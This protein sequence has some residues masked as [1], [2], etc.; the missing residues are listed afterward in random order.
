MPGERT[1]ERTSHFTSENRFPGQTHQTAAGRSL[2]ANFRW[3]GSAS[4]LSAATPQS[5]TDVYRLVRGPQ[6]ASSW[7]TATAATNQ[8]RP[9]DRDVSGL[10]SQPAAQGS[11]A[12]RDSRLLRVLLFVSARADAGDLHRPP[13]W[14]ESHSQLSQR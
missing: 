1:H 12:R 5:R 14:E 9:H 11:E 4:E 8:V 13:V 3:S 7:S 2:S 10:L 6:S